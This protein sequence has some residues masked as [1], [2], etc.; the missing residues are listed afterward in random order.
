M[1]TLL[2][3]LLLA[4]PGLLLAADFQ[5]GVAKTIITPPLPIWLNGYA[6]RTNAAASVKSD[7]WAKALA[8]RDNQGGQVVIVTTDLVGLPREVS[9]AAA[10]RVRQKHGL[11]R[12]QVLFNSSHTHSGPVVWPGLTL[13]FAFTPEE[14]AHIIRYTRKL[15]DDLVA[16]IGAALADRSPARLSFAQGTAAFAINRRQPTLSGVQLGVNTNGPVDHSVPVLKVSAP[17]GTLR[18][19]LTGYA[20]HNT[21]LGGDFYQVDGDYAGCAQRELERAHPGAAA[22][23]LILCGGDQNPQPRGRYENV[24]QHGRTL[25]A[26]VEQVL[27]GELKPV[28]PPIR[29]A[30]QTAELDFAPHTRKQFEEEAAGK[31]VYRQR[32]AK[33][34]LESYDQGQPIRHLPYPV[35]AVRFNTDLTLLALANEVVVD[36]AHRARREYPAETM[37]V[38][39]YCNE[40]SCYIPS[41]RVLRE[42]GYEPVDS[43]IYYGQPGPFAENVEET[44]FRCVREVMAQTGARGKP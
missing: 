25:A 5:A 35:Q 37:V 7:L 13:M 41:L 8:L 40:V 24:E 43:M 2:S 34:M 21:T 27:R 3:F 33:L 15:T 20:C 22:L 29:T 30:W 18:A 17:D 28:L 36:Y 4:W 31:N 16:V 14:K 6:A 19:V 10:D 38:A 23:F 12:E 11:K 1:K 39:G 26:A 42:G 32:R 44:I 9:E